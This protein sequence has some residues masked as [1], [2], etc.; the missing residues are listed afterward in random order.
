MRPMRWLATRYAQM[1]CG[2]V[3]EPLEQW[4]EHGGVFWAWSTEETIV[5]A[6][7]R[8]LPRNLS[9]LAV[10][11][12]ASTVDCPWCLDF[13]SHLGEKT[14]LD[15]TKVQDLHRWRESSAYDDVERDVLDYAE[16]ISATPIEVD[17]ALRERLRDRLGTK[18]LVELTA[19]VALENQR[20]RF[21]A[22]MGVLPQGW[23]RVCALPT[24][25][26]SS[27]EAAKSGG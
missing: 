16:Q 7:W 11:K 17:D 13:G 24:P 3:P 22:A 23:S 2:K 21:N 20:S 18:G 27:L 8:A 6:T 26:G 19:Y 14:G 4:A 12:S 25:A 10:L 9:T 1:R 5:D 15:A